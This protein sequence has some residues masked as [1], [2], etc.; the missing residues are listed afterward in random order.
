M[1]LS[2]AK[3]DVQRCMELLCEGADPNLATGDGTPLL[4]LA[5]AHADTDRT[6]ALVQVK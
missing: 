6:L 1:I 4:H 5:L 2:V 3:G